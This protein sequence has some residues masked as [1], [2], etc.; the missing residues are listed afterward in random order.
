[1]K[2]AYVLQNLGPAAGNIQAATI[3]DSALGLRYRGQVSTADALASSLADDP[4]SA[5]LREKAARAL[6]EEGRHA[7]AIALLEEG[8]THLNAHDP[9]SLPC[10]CRRCIT[11]EEVRTRVGDATFVR[12]FTVAGG[13]VLFYW[14]PEELVGQLP[15]VRRS[16][17][18][19]L[20][21]RLRL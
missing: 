1:M 15:R 21:A 2:G 8:F 4:E 7:E 13:R 9:G 19:S 20:R 16:V 5:E 17:H 6:A 12:D 3:A 11:A 18:G 10:L 14:V